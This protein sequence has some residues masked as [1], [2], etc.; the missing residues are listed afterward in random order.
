MFEHP[1]AA[2]ATQPPPAAA[3]R[4]LLPAGVLDTNMKI[5]QAIGLQYAQY[6]GPVLAGLLC[7]TAQGAL[8]DRHENTALGWL[9]LF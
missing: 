7:F 5:E 4:L 3:C 6:A 1:P 8:P 9:R 2:R